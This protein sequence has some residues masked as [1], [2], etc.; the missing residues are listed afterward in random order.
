M[1]FQTYVGIFIDG[2]ERVLLCEPWMSDAVGN[3]LGGET[4]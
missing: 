2:R 1:K 4:T 3:S